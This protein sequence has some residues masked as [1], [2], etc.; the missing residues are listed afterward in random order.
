MMNVSAAVNVA[1]VVGAR[2]VVG[3][4]VVD[5]CAARGDVVVPVDTG[6][7]S[8]DELLTSNAFSHARGTRFSRSA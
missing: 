3:A 2:D 7:A 1:V 4:A 8:F 6:I 5:A